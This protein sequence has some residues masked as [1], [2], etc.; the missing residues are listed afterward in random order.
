MPSWHDCEQILEQPDLLPWLILADVLYEPLDFRYR[1]IGRRI[2]ER[3]RADF[4]G[5]RFSELPHTSPASKVWQ[6]RAAVVQ[7]RAPLLSE[8]P[9]TGKR[10]TVRRVSGFHFP[11]S[12]DGTTVNMIMTAVSFAE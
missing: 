4:T 10:P 3:S 2:A 6:E 11:L 8:P 5:M 9:Y 7:S 1:F 12:D